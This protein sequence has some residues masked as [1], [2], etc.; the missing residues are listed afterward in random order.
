MALTWN[1]DAVKAEM[2]KRGNAVGYFAA[3]RVAQLAYQYAPKDTLTLANSIF[4]DATPDHPKVLVYVGAPYAVF[5]ELG[6]VH[7][8]SGQWIPG[9]HFLRRAL[10]DVA[11]AYPGI[12]RQEFWRDAAT[13][14]IGATP[15]R[16]T[17]GAFGKLPQRAKDEFMEGAAHIGVGLQ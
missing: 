12:V 15:E 13:G 4:I 11:Q 14:G 9:V 6:F 5:Q 10:M 7:Y 17:P 8:Q 3:E 1:G 2:I 16:G